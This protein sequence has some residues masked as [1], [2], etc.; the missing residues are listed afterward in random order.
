MGGRV[1]LRIICNQIKYLKITTI[2]VLQPTGVTNKNHTSARVLQSL[3]TLSTPQGPLAFSDGTLASGFRQ[4]ISPYASAYHLRAA[5]SL[6][7]GAIAR[8]S[9][10]RF[11]HPIANSTGTGYAQGLS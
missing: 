3:A 1:Y 11:W 5:L 10:Q 9:L 2:S 4:L 6:G 8:H 7:D